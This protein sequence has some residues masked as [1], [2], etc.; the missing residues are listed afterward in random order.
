MESFYKS[1]QKAKLGGLGLRDTVSYKQW[2]EL[3]SIKLKMEVGAQVNINNSSKC[4]SYVKWR[5]LPK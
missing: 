5:T 2:E 3:W 4:L 1:D